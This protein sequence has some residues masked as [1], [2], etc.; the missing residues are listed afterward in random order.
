[1]STPLKPSR[2]QKTGMEPG[3]LVYV[4]D[5]NIKPIRITVFRYNDKLCE[6]HHIQ[7]VEAL[8]EWKNHEDIIWINIDGVHDVALIERM[9]QIFE[10]DSLSL[11][12]MLNTHTRPKFDEYEGYVF[13]VIKDVFVENDAL[14]A[15][16]MSFVL[17]DKLLIS[18]Q[19]EEG[20]VFEPIRNRLRTGSSRARMRG[21]DYLMYS[22]LDAIVDNYFVICEW[23]DKSIDELEERLYTQSGKPELAEI[24]DT[25]H[26]FNNLKRVMLPGRE[27]VYAFYKT[28]N[29]LVKKRTQVFIRDMMDHTVHIVE[30]LDQSWDKVNGLMHIYL[31][32]TNHT[33]NN[34]MK[35]LTIISTIFMC[36]SLIAGIYGMNFRHIPELEWRYGYFIILGGM[37]L[38]SLILLL[39]FRRK[40]WL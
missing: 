16:Q 19:E 35:T 3:S 23:F 5:A 28:E 30:T 18:F 8:S 39:F 2:I 12:D 37:G 1:M 9:G 33:M 29:P 34:I 21:A 40:R 27:V 11:E 14:L 31:S 7:N 38:L 17:K 10:L 24:I 20:D 4:G 15:E 22:L 6:E 26:E 36:L 25:K 13:C 32:G